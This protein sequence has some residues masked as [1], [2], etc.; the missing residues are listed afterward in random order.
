M[1]G[2]DSQRLLL[3]REPRSSPGIALLF[4]ASIDFFSIFEEMNSRNHFGEM[5]IDGDPGIDA[6]W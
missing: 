5:G 2:D 4:S 6:P 1:G 3:W